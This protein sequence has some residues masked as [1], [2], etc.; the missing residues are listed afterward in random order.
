MA[1][2]KTSPV[3]HERLYIGKN[4]LRKDGGC[5]IAYVV[6]L[7]DGSSW[8]C[9]PSCIWLGSWEMSVYL[10]PVIYQ[11]LKNVEQGQ[12]PF[13]LCY[14]L[15]SMPTETAALNKAV[16]DGLQVQVF[17]GGRCAKACHGNS[18]PLLHGI[19]EG[20]WLAQPGTLLSNV[21]L[22]GILTHASWVVEIKRPGLTRTGTGTLPTSW[23]T[24]QEG[25]TTQPQTYAP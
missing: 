8:A 17:F 1:V 21:I 22:L 3:I 19:F 6:I 18:L 13:H 2:S 10:A 4:R 12:N 20:G 23:A 16:P 25:D 11:C 7:F 9:N 24:I 15:P 14:T 5:H